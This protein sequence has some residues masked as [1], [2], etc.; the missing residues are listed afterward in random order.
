MTMRFKRVERLLIVTK[1]REKNN[2]LTG[3]LN[4]MLDEI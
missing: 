2:M 1:R 4:T 3:G